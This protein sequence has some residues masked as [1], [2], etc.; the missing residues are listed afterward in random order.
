MRKV[1]YIPTDFLSF[2]SLTPG[3]VYDVIN[4]YKGENINYDKV[5]VVNDLGNISCYYVY[6]SDNITCILEDITSEYRNDIIDG[7]LE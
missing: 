7:I 4:Y 1:K 5:D 2:K 6:S 3:K